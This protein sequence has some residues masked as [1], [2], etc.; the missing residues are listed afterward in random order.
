MNSQRHVHLTTRRLRLV[1]PQTAE[2]AM[3]LCIL[4][5][6]STRKLHVRGRQCGNAAMR[7]CSNA[8]MRL[9]FSKALLA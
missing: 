7:Q 8:A 9:S 6:T 4:S 5:D 1:K 3:Y 2:Q